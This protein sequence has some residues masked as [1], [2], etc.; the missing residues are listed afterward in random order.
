[1]LGT[2]VDITTMDFS[3][4]DAFPNAIISGVWQIGTC[5]HGTIVGNEFTKVAD[6]DVII[7]EG[8]N[9][10]INATPESL[11]ADLLVYVYPNQLPTVNTNALV[12][13]YMLYDSQ[14]D[15]YYAITDA[16]VGK[17][18]HTGRIEH[19]ELKLTQTEV[20]NE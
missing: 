4:F 17:N 18:Q 13:E 15:H 2:A 6:I 1:M 14:N 3:I 11:T 19:L 12:S 16:G 7:D 10:D 8:N 20:V 9:S 5:Q